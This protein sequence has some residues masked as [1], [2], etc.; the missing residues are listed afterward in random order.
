MMAPASA[1][2]ALLYAPRPKLRPFWDPRS[3][4][5]DPTDWSVDTWLP[6]LELLVLLL[7][8]ATLL[9]VRF[10]LLLL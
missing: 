4:I 7:V 1:F 8:A 10:A 5:S 2:Q 3:V 6:L 9:A